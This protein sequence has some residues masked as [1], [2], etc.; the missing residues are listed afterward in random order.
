MAT[1]RTRAPTSC[2]GTTGFG[3]HR[4]KQVQLVDAALACK[5]YCIWQLKGSARLRSIVPRAISAPPTSSVGPTMDMK[6]ADAEFL[7]PSRPMKVLIAGGGIAGL[8]LAVAL[9]KKG[10]DVRVFEQ[11][12]TAIRGEGKYRGPIQ[13]RS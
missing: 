10:V 6:A 5:Q 4:S 9:L 2:A 13:V 8:V 11:D 12:M 7:V 1:L 3:K